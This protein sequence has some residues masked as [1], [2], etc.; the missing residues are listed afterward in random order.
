M[1]TAKRMAPTARKQATGTVKCRLRLC[2]D[3]FRQAKS[4]PAPVRKSR[5]MP[6]GTLI[7][8]K[9]GALTVI[10]SPLTA[11]ESTGNMVPHRMAKHTPTSARLFSRKLLSLETKE[12][13]SLRAFRARRRLIRS[14]KD[15]T[16][17][18][19]TKPMNM[20]PMPEVVKEWTDETTP[21]RV[22]KVPK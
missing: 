11:S 12:S 3:V 16:I 4:G 17:E 19:M 21:L 22:R 10:F 6:S 15:N 2:T 14:P 9:Y 5:K 7:W 13:S 1:P 18:T 8:L 20:G